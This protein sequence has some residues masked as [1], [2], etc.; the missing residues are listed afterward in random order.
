MLSR[1]WRSR[2]L[3]SGSR[4][5]KNLRDRRMRR[6]SRTTQTGTPLSSDEEEEQPTAQKGYKGEVEDLTAKGRKADSAKKGARKKK[7][8]QQQNGKDEDEEETKELPWV[9]TAMEGSG[10]YENCLG[11]TVVPVTQLSRHDAAVS[12]R[13]SASVTDSV[14]R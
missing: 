7:R 3:L 2:G 8:K 5:E 11:Q 12:P 6:T 14:Y 1:L 13:L 4:V 10:F 9:G